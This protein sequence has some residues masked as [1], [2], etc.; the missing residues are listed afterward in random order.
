MDIIRPSRI[1]W[2]W[3]LWTPSAFS[4]EKIAWRTFE[5]SRLG[6]ISWFRWIGLRGN[7]NRKP[8]LFYHQIDRAF[9]SKCS[10][11]PI[12]LWLEF[13]MKL[14]YVGLLGGWNLLDLGA[15][16]R[17]VLVQLQTE[18]CVISG[19]HFEDNWPNSWF[20]EMFPSMVGLESAGYISRRPPKN[21]TNISTANVSKKWLEDVGGIFLQEKR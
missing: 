3:S 15:Q 6:Q 7:L 13:R 11:N 21:K 1:S 2:P 19:G 8:W 20:M 10:H 18:N 16:K 5:A 4:A 14:V 12:L 17:E 9:R